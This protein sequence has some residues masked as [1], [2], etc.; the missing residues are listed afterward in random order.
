[1]EE[2]GYAS[3]DDRG[4]LLLIIF[5]VIGRSSLDPAVYYSELLYYINLQEPTVAS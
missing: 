5:K 1:M 4:G 2:W 3:E